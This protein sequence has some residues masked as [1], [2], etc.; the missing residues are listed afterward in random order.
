MVTCSLWLYLLGHWS[1]T[2]ANGKLVN[3][4]AG[5]MPGDFPTHRKI[6]LRLKKSGSLSKVIDTIEGRSTE[7][8]GMCTICQV[9]I[10][11]YFHLTR[12]F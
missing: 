9:D 5:A 1:W 11:I 3:C 4:G 12:M 8:Y 7:I 6:E 10:V 2:R